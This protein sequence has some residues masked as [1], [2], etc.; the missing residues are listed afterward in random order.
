MEVELKGFLKVLIDEGTEIDSWGLRNQVAY[1]GKVQTMH[2]KHYTVG[3][4]SIQVQSWCKRQHNVLGTPM[5]GINN[6]ER[7]QV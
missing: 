1:I 4:R 3:I 5:S 7:K 6:L 2:G